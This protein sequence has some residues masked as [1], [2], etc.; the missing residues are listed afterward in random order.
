[1][2]LQVLIIED[3][4]D[5]TELIVRE[6]RRAGHE[7]AWERVFD[8]PGLRSA[9]ARTKWDVVLSDWSLPGFSALAALA[10]A[11]AIRPE[12][13]FIIVTGTID[14]ATAVDAMRAGARD[15]IVKSRLARLVPA[16]ERET[17]EAR[18]REQSR[19]ALNLSEARFKRVVESGIVG[20]VLGDIHGQIFTT[21]EAFRSMLGYE[22]PDA[23]LNWLDLT[24][25]EWH[26]PGVAMVES[27][28]TAGGA[29]AR[30]LELFH[31][32]GH[33][34]PVLVGAVMVDAPNCLSIVLD[35]TDRKRAEAEL[36]RM[37]DQLRQAQ[38]LEA[39][40]SLAG[41]IAHDFNNILSVIL[42][43]SELAVDDLHEGDPMREGLLEV[44]GAAQRAAQLTRQLLAFSRRQILQPKVLDLRDVLTGMENMLRRL[45]GE[46][47]E[48][49]LRTG[50]VPTR[51]LVDPA[52]ITQV[53]MNLVI[54]GRDA[55]PAGG[56]LS[57]ETTIVELDQHF[58]DQ[59]VGSRSGPHVMLAITDAG[60]GMDRATL[61]RIFEPFFTTKG[62]EKG[63][64]LGLSTV[65]G[66]VQQSGGTIW[67]YSEVGLGTTFKIYLPLAAT[68]PAEV[69]ATPIPSRRHGTETILLVEDDR[70]LRTLTT[71]LLQRDGY[72]VLTAESPGDALLIVEQHP[73]I[74]L[75][76]TD[77][78]MPRMS[79]RQLAERLL[80]LR[81]GLS[82]LYM[83]GYTDDAVVRHGVLASEME[84]LQKPFTPESL[85]RR[86]R[87]VL[88]GTT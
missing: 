88:D 82:V 38:K 53:V 69:V 24:P 65:L 44:V 34:V 58:A 19:A 6:L 46:D 51:V 4:D 39:I 15:V 68:A 43:Y 60:S 42:S 20:F 59:H 81:P 23:S 13:P 56:L 32:D 55:M 67:V 66:I 50:P 85:A 62:I 57:I 2:T 77:V 33:R 25:P 31:E 9:L 40:G 11:T 87:E 5:D 73:A 86:V 28:E 27:L 45:I 10:E 71:T 76:L 14:E 79:G 54:N 8:A 41:G 36:A 30:E 52:Q 84:Y 29:A 21:N 47:I 70:A 18:E 26:A 63:T 48:L 64:G 12:V 61:A 49:S 83:S 22:Q 35:L 16:V 78:V 72:H 74:D 37:Q 75:L 80:A 3:S 7:V 17:R 1:M